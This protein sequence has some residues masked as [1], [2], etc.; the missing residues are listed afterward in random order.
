MIIT[1]HEALTSVTV[2]G[3]SYDVTRVP[4]WLQHGLLLRSERWGGSNFDTNKAPAG[5]RLYVKIQVAER[6]GT[7]T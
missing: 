2:F 7:L 3:R 1:P 4:D 5:D 6:F